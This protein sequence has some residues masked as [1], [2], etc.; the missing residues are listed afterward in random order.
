MHLQHHVA[1]GTYN[2]T[3]KR[4]SLSKNY[5]SMFS[6]LFGGLLQFQRPCF[7]VFLLI[8]YYHIIII[9]LALTVGLPCLYK[10]NRQN[11]SMSK[12]FACIFPIHTELNLFFLIILHF[13][14]KQKSYIAKRL[15]KFFKLKPKFGFTAVFA[16]FFSFQLVAM[17][18]LLIIIC[19]QARSQRR[20]E[21]PPPLSASRA[22]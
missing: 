6:L 7:T 5:P 1:T 15:C 2:Q 19:Y 16:S 12:E 17:N 21:L 22:F 14:F 9:T 4:V 10:I 3:A 11:I 20:G 8:W 13:L 18:L